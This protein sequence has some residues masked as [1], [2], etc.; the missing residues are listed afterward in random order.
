MMA[1]CNSRVLMV[2]WSVV[3]CARAGATSFIAGQEVWVVRFVV[4]CS[5]LPG[6]TTIEYDKVNPDCMIAL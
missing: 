6:L 1:G 2:P 5:P 3:S 4:E